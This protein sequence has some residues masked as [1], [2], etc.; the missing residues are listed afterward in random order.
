M[1]KQQALRQ[2]E[3]IRNP[4]AAALALGANRAQ[5]VAPRKGRGSFSRTPKHRVR[6]F[7]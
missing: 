3:A 4:M 7:G 6:D 1:K 2:V 5:T